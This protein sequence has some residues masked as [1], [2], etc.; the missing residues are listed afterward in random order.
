MSQSGSTCRNCTFPRRGFTRRQLTQ[1]K[2]LTQERLCV[3]R[4]TRMIC[5]GGPCSGTEVS[6]GCKA[7]YPA[8]YLCLYGAES[9]FEAQNPQFS[10]QKGAR[11]TARN[12]I[13][14]KT[15]RTMRF[16][17]TSRRLGARRGARTSWPCRHHS[18][19]QR[20]Q[21]LPATFRSQ[22]PPATPSARILH[23]QRPSRRATGLP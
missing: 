15:L 9:D 3:A 16:G 7:I 22:L 4:R 20:V 13:Q 8:Q 6:Q 2:R 19:S 18:E 21:Q 11:L 14:F 1:W 10:R 5:A 12:A 17:S 23:S